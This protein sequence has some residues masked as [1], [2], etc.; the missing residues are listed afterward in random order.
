MTEATFAFLMWGIGLLTGF[1][2]GRLVS[3]TFFKVTR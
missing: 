2:L 3:M 1:C